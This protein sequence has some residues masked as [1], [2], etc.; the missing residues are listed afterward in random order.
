M[1]SHEDLVDDL[2]SAAYAS[3]RSLATSELDTALRGAH[4]DLD[5]AK[6]VLGLAPPLVVPEQRMAQ[7][8]DRLRALDAELAS[9]SQATQP[10]DVGRADGDVLD[11]GLECVYTDRRTDMTFNVKILNV[12]F[13]DPP[14]YYTI[15]MPD[16]N[17]RETVRE[18]LTRH[19]APAEVSIRLPRA[20]AAATM[21]QRE[22]APAPQQPG[23]DMHAIAVQVED[24]LAN[25]VNPAAST[26]GLVSVLLGLVPFAW[27]TYLYA[28]SASACSGGTAVLVCTPCDRRVLGFLYASAAC[29]LALTVLQT[30]VSCCA[31]CCCDHEVEDVQGCA[32]VLRP[33]RRAFAIVTAFVWLKGIF[34]VLSADAARDSC[35]AAT[36]S[37]A[38]SVVLY[39]LIAVP[40]AV[41]L[42]WRV[43][44]DAM[45][46]APAR[47][48]GDKGPIML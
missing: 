10:G 16:G 31:P 11:K 45:R 40:C 32:R 4:G 23:I 13:D 22:P 9:S 46:K 43:A 3:G 19:S 34:D 7:L 26:F 38:R 39:S 30:A 41:A 47:V 5:A 1:A 27:C 29:A 15:R 8:E 44:H 37:G 14:P 28:S 20:P 33:L 25:C 2:R 35:D 21:A 42:G 12:H 36:L 6:R 17:E 24:D 48:S 18:R